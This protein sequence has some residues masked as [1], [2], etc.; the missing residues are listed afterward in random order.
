[1]Y[2]FL[3]RR[4][5]SFFIIFIILLNF[6]YIELFSSNGI[7]G[8]CIILAILV[9]KIIFSK[10][11]SSFS[12]VTICEIRVILPKSFGPIK[13]YLSTETIN[14]IIVYRIFLCSVI[15]VL[16][17]NYFHNICWEKIDFE[18]GGFFVFSLSVSIFSFYFMKG[19]Y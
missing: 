13:Y 2:Y 6:L 4:Q 3:R 15:F 11:S 1:M 17:Q 14:K 8:H 7:L 9:L 5:L 18:L 12:Y 19:A 10:I 16:Q